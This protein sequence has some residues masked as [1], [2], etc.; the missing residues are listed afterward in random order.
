[1]SSARIPFK[2]YQ[3]ESFGSMSTYFPSCWVFV[4][5]Y[6]GPFPFSSGL[7]SFACLCSFLHHSPFEKRILKKTPVNRSLDLGSLMKY[8]GTAGSGSGCHRCLPGVTVTMT[9]LLIDEW[10]YSAGTLTNS[11]LKGS[12]KRTPN[13]PLSF[14]AKQPEERLASAGINSSFSDTCIHDMSGKLNGSHYACSCL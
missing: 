10:R 9:W 8:S 13:F 5:P 14:K 11:S 6:A 2:T 1:M 4:A 12:N 7:A 3:R